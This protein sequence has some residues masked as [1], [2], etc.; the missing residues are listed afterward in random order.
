MIQD[1]KTSLID[2]EDD[3]SSFDEADRIHVVN[4]KIQGFPLIFFA[5]ERNS[6]EL[7]RLILEYG[8]DADTQNDY[9]FPS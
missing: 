6:A 9:G 4:G 2:I 8:V 1:C 5:V 7:V 3:L